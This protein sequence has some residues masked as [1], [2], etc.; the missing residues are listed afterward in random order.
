MKTRNTIP[1][2]ALAVSII[3]AAPT[4]L[5]LGQ[6]ASDLRPDLTLL[7]DR[8]AEP[9]FHS[10]FDGKDLAGWQGHPKLWSVKDGAITGQTTAE[11]PAKKNTFLIWTNEM[12]GDFEFRCSFKIIPNNNQGFA[13]SG[14]QFRSKVVDPDYWVVGGYQADMEAGPNYTGT[15]YEEGSPRQ[16]MALRG[17]K[18]VWG[19]DCRKQVVGS[20]GEAGALQA[21]IKP[22]EWNEYVITAEGNHLREF[23]NGKQMVDVTDDCEE[24]RAMSGV[25]ALQLHAGPPMTVQFKDLRM[26]NLSQKSATD[27]KSE[28]QGIWQVTGM[29]N[30][31]TALPRGELASVSLTIKDNSYRLASQN[32]SLNGIFSIDASKKPK[33]VT[34][35]PGDGGSD[36]LTL[37]GIYELEQDHLR[38]CYGAPGGECPTDFKTDN[39]ERTLITC[40]RKEP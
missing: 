5:L 14:I 32:G 33:Q 18:V 30:N 9:S 21:A 13:N 38:V 15:L 23:I 11:N 35:R 7:Q 31:G 12:V 25:L 6:P 36:G 40:K 34:L 19:K 26:K 22:G 1:P 4:G 24:R 28:L 2:L 3:F 39:S 8:P 37:M 27:V 20:L 29:E 10:L 16:T 17:E